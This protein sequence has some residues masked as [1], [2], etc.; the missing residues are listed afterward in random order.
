L[1]AKFI[2]PNY[3]YSPYHPPRRRGESNEDFLALQQLFVI[4]TDWADALR[5][6]NED[7]LPLVTVRIMDQVVQIVQDGL[8]YPFH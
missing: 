6:C 1:Y 7:L 3:A 2:I 5:F 8:L 4:V